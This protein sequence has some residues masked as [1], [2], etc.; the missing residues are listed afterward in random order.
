MQQI[1]VGAPTEASRTYLVLH[2]DENRGDLVGKHVR[3]RSSRQPLACHRDDI[4]P[5]GQ[6]IQKPGMS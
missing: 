4:K 1:W 3:I 2:H 5:L 6:L